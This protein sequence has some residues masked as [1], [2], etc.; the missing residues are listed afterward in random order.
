MDIPVPEIAEERRLEERRRLIECVRWHF[1]PPAWFFDQ[2]EEGIKLAAAGK[3]DE[4]FDFDD[5]RYR[6]GEIVEYYDLDDFIE[7]LRLS[8]EEYAEEHLPWRRP[9]DLG[10]DVPF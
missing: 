7:R 1:L 8:D 3:V 5:R 9:L 10:G 6:V 4:M 2:L